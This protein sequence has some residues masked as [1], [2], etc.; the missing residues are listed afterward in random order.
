MERSSQYYHD[1]W[2]SCD[3]RLPE[4]GKEVLVWY[5][6]FRYGDYNCMYQTFGIGYQFGGYWGG[7]VQGAKAKCLAWRPLPKPYIPQEKRLKWKMRK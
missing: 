4:D 1:D 2:I 5:E 7:D 6:Y 3:E